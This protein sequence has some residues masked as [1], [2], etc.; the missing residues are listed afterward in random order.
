MGD[1]A[2]GLP[3]VPGW[4]RKSTATVLRRYGSI[5]AIPPDGASWDVQVLSARRLA[6]TLVEWRREV[7][8]YR[9]LIT[10][11]TDV[12][13]PDEVEDLQGRG[14]KRDALE[15][16]CERLDAPKILDRIPVW[17]PG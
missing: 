7:V 5:E 6:A 12:P 2:G 8:I 13:I 11:A 4:G 1:R 14:A 10:L 17:R 9:E 3:G 15:A 16:I